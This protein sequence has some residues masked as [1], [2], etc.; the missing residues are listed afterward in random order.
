MKSLRHVFQLI[1]TALDYL[2]NCC[3]LIT[4][5]MDENIPLITFRENIKLGKDA[6]IEHIKRKEER[7]KEQKSIEN[8]H[9]C[10]RSN[11]AIHLSD[12]P[13]VIR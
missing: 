4:D 11:L 12:T 9:P 2:D 7:G 13:L 5:D 3:T 10:V 6:K 1:L 8:K